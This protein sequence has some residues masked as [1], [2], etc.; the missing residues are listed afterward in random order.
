MEK[1]NQALTSLKFIYSQVAGD[2][3]IDAEMA[4]DEMSIKLEIVLDE[5]QGEIEE[6]FDTKDWEVSNG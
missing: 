5:V 2:R 3:G 6:H 1:L 4:W